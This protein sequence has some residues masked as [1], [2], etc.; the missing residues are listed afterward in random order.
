MAKTKSNNNS[1]M[2]PEFHGVFYCSGLRGVGKS[3]LMSQVER[4][5]LTCYL[6]FDDGKGR[7]LDEQLHFGSYRDVMAEMTVR[8]GRVY[9]PQQ[10]YEYLD[11]LLKDIDQDRFTHCVLD[12]I[13][14]IEQALTVEVKRDPDAYGIGRN[15]KS[16][17]SNAVTGAFGGPYPGVNQLVSGL[18]STLHARGVRVVSAIAHVKS[19]WSAGGIVYNKWKPRGVERWQQMS[20]LSLV[21]IPGTPDPLPPAALVQKEA[22]GKIKFNNE[23][24][25]FEKPVRR[26][27]LRLPEANF[28]EIR[29]YLKKPADLKNPRP[30]EVPTPEETLPFSE[31]FSKEQLTYMTLAAQIEL[32]RDDERNLFAVNDDSLEHAKSMLADGKSAKQ[33][34]N[35]L[36]L[37][38]SDLAKAGLI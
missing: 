10:M 11:L 2:P 7:G 15:N 4:P 28:A 23:T 25:E 9:K 22:L 21:L 26:L 6:D 20:I 19:V 14:Y 3:T 27:P 29:R 24:Q 37:K 33:V 31:K 12:N 8:Y 18:I 36:G 38:V 5:D 35:D 30:G 1:I 13:D 17:V 16:G 34:A 32:S